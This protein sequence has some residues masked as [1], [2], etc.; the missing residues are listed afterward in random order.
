MYM[1]WA[2]KRFGY[3]EEEWA[4]LK[5][6]LSISLR[7]LI[8]E[9][10]FEDDTDLKSYLLLGPDGKSSVVKDQAWEHLMSVIDAISK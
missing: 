10:E 5:E 6:W 8:Y 2:G 4:L 3:S 7:K 1:W 9:E